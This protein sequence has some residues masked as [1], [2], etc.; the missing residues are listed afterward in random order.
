MRQQL[1][2]LLVSGHE[3]SATTLAWALFHVH[4]DEKV[5]RKLLDELA[6]NPGLEQ[7][8]KLP[9]L[10]PETA[11]T[12]EPWAVGYVELGRL[13]RVEGRL[14]D[15]DPKELSFGME[16]EVVVR[17]FRIAGDGTEVYTFGFAPAGGQR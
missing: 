16:F 11:E 1:R 15:V 8:P 2:T 5:R 14:Y 12:F 9:Y 6:N 10:G 17:P 7:L 4:A 3:T 13:L